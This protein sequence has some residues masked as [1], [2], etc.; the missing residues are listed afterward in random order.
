MAGK[1]NTSPTNAQTV[2]HINDECTIL[3]SVSYRWKGNEM[4]NFAVTCN[5]TNDWWI[6]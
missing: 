6:L 1:L 2:I 5:N 3:L 4:Y